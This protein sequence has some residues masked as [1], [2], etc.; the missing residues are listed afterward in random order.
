MLIIRSLYAIL[1]LERKKNMDCRRKM[2]GEIKLSELIPAN[3]QT[4]DVLY[5]ICG[6]QHT[7]EV[8][9]LDALLSVVLEVLSAHYN[10]ITK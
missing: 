6:L 5:S 10:K 2:P 3:G 7:K 1:K 4:K 8:V 9:N